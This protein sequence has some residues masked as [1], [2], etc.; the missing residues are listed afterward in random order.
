MAGRN[1]SISPRRPVYLA[2][3]RVFRPLVASIG[4]AAAFFVLLDCSSFG[5]A[6]D[7]AGEPDA[8][9]AAP[10]ASMDVVADLDGGKCPDGAFCDDFDEGELGARWS[11]IAHQG[12]RRMALDPTAPLS[13]PN[14]FRVEIPGDAGP[15]LVEGML[16]LDLPVPKELRCS[17]A[18]RN[19]RALGSSRNVDLFHLR[20]EAPGYEAYTLKLGGTSGFGLR[21]DIDLADGGCA[22]PRYQSGERFQLEPGVWKRIVLGTNFTT[23]T[24]WVEGDV[25]AKEDL[26]TV[27]PSRVT[28][29]LGLTTRTPTDADMSFDDF[30]CELFE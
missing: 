27:A 1:C 4:C 6:V 2:V 12:A 19:E 23:V 15:R 18:V 24:L 29:R 7:P 17:F 25:V 8:A 10:D 28:V 9:S 26:T 5:S 22:C 11:N 14:V 13:P 20:L 21:E 30:M 3:V 16:E